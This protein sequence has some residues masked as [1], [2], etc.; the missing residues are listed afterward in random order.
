[1]QDDNLLQDVIVVYVCRIRETWPV[2]Y[3]MF[4]NNAFVIREPGRSSDVVL[5]T[6]APSI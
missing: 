3:Q 4:C 2:T 6:E 5:P 1:M